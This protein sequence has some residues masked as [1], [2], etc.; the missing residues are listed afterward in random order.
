MIRISPSGERDFF[1][2][3]VDNSIEFVKIL[4]HD[5]QVQ[6]TVDNIQLTFDAEINKNV[7]A[8]SVQIDFLIE[9]R[10]KRIIN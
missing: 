10:K 7:F 1:F 8:V 5:Q 4:E 9:Q 2:K 6:S 3:Q